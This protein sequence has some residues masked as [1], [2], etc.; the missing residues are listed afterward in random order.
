MKRATT[1]D[2]VNERKKE[3]IDAVSKMFDTIDYQDISMKTISEHI[4]I[5]RSSLYCYYK[6]KEEIMLDILKEDYLLFLSELTNAIKNKNN[7]VKNTTDIYLKHLKLLKIIS[8]YLTDIEN[9]CSLDSL[10]NFKAS[11]VKPFD[12]LHE[13]FIA[14][15]PETPIDTIETIISS[16]LILTHGLYPMIYPNDNQVKAMQ[17]VKM[18]YCNNPY[19]Y[20][21]DYLNLIFFNLL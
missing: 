14:S 6:S 17:K 4:S 13:T 1:S 5:A 2:Q 3:I 19:K 21:Y 18:N 12:I 10:V 9:H 11:F 8:V 15:Y 7:I 16:L 20:C